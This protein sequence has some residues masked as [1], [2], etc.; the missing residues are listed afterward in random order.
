M[1]KNILTFIFL[2][3]L[4]IACS[5][6]DEDPSQILIRKPIRGNAVIAFQLTADSSLPDN[7]KRA[8]IGAVEEWNY[9]TLNR[10]DY[11]VVFKDMSKESNDY[12]KYIDEYRLYIKQLDPNYVGWTNWSARANSASIYIDHGLTE[13]YF[14]SVLM[15]ELG[16]ALDLS[17]NG[18]IHYE[19]PY[20][21]VMR[22][23]TYDNS[24]V[25]CPELLSF[26]I[27]YNCQINC[28]YKAIETSLDVSKSS[29]EIIKLF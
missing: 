17:F 15:H 22:S 8:V 3:L 4:L 26:C 21:S 12:H 24:S 16:H 1:Y 9:K 18:K 14:R 23:A 11:T 6:N 5:A 2:S 13:S 20:L 28:E 29:Q 7:L 10:L 19:G 25:E 27:R